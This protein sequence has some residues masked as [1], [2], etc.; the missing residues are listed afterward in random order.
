MGRLL[1]RNDPLGFLDD[2]HQLSTPLIGN[3]V[4][5]T[6]GVELCHLAV[7]YQPVRGAA[8]VGDQ[9]PLLGS[10]P[11]AGLSRK[12]RPMSQ[13][14]AL[15]WHVGRCRMIE[16]G[17]MTERTSSFCC[18]LILHFHFLPIFP[19]FQS[20]P[21]VSLLISF[22]LCYPVYLKLCIVYNVNSEFIVITFYIL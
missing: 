9:F 11:A 15:S 18:G 17:A 13:Y 6:L 7:P 19:F 20:F 10:T 12:T 8:V 16:C 5:S 2:L 4:S 1:I 14:P 22:V 3:L 21:S